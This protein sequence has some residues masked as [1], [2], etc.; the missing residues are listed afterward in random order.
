MEESLRWS[1]REAVF[2]YLNE[3]LL[4]GRIFVHSGTYSMKLGVSYIWRHLTVY[5]EDFSFVTVD[6]VLHNR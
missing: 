6:G 5:W 4:R 2:D 3:G 1:T